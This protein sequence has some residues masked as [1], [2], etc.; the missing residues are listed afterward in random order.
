MRLGVAPKITKSILEAESGPRRSARGSHGRFRRYVQVMADMS[1]DGN[2]RPFAPLA[3]SEVETLLGF[4]S[5][6]RATLAW[7]CAG[8]TDE[9]LRVALPPSTNTLGGLLKHMAY[10]EDGWFAEV[11]GATRSPSRG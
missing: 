3:G 6:Q 2:T 5:Y 1:T 10:V 7:K 11:V 9:Q 8:L 4:L